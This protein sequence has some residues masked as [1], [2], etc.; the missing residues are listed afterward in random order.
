MA[1]MWSSVRQTHL[2][3]THALEGSNG[4]LMGRKELWREIHWTSVKEM[5]SPYDCMRQRKR[6]SMVLLQPG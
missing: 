1:E 4:L 6:K 5:A 2:L 3:L